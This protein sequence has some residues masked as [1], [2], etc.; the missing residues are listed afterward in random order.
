[1]ALLRFLVCFFALAVAV[2]EC[3]RSLQKRS[4]VQLG[5]M[6]KF[7]RSKFARL[8]TI[9]EDCYQLYREPDIHSFCRWG[10]E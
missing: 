2:N 5:C 6:G 7:D 10:I 1:M 3:G 9:C 4:F 8:D